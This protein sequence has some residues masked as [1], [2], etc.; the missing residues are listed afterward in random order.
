MINYVYS[1]D[2]SM[3]E[4]RKDYIWGVKIAAVESAQTLV[5]IKVNKPP[6]LPPIIIIE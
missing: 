4:R 2:R 3:T 1:W 6:S 5:Y